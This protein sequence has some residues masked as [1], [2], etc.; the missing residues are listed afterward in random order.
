MRRRNIYT[1]YPAFP[2]TKE[3]SSRFFKYYE[4]SQFENLIRPVENTAIMEA[5][6]RKLG[7]DVEAVDFQHSLQH[8]GIFRTYL[9]MEKLRQELI[10]FLYYRIEFSYQ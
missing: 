6:C 4:E 5:V 3:E 10:R 9:H 1:G 2:G 7:L 8:A